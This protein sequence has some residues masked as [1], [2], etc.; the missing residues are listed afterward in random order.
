VGHA[1]YEERIIASCS[2][3]M[4]PDTEVDTLVAGPGVYICN[5]CI[6]ACAALANARDRRG[7]RIAPWERELSNDE[8]LRILPQ[9]A[10]AGALAD[11]ALA[12]WVRK[13]RAQGVSWA[14]IGAA[15]GTTRQAAWERFSAAS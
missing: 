15:L 4:R 11:H 6:D 12:E 1:D 2:F 3:C 10:M 5:T 9:V 13:A 8:L 14:R 7:A